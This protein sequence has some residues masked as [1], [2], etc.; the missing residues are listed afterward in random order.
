VAGVLVDDAERVQGSG[1]LEAVQPVLALGLL[2][3]GGKQPL[4]LGVVAALARG[5]ALRE[6]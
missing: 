5:G 1:Q 2:D 6:R 4:G 3:G